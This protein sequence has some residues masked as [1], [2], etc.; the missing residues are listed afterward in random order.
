MMQEK[1]FQE[2][3]SSFRGGRV[4]SRIVKARKRKACVRYVA[5]VSLKLGLNLFCDFRLE[6][7]QFEGRL[8]F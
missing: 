5:C 2:F 3:S 7:G 8:R 6:G 4:L 1:A